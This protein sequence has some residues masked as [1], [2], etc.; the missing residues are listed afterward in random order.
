MGSWELKADPRKGEFCDPQLTFISF[1]GVSG[2]MEHPRPGKPSLGAIC[3]S[4]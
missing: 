1:S 2:V 3:P 4:L